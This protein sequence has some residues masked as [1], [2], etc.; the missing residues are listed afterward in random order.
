MQLNSMEWLE[1]EFELQLE[2]ESDLEYLK[3]AVAETVVDNESDFF[4]II[5]AICAQLND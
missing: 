2:P 5:G 3:N 1:V 4:P